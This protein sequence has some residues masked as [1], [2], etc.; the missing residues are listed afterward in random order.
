MFIALLA[1]ASLWLAAR[2]SLS[3]TQDQL[4]SVQGQISGVQSS[5]ASAT[6]KIA[7]D[8]SVAASRQAEHNAVPDSKAV[9]AKYFSSATGDAQSVELTISGLQVYTSI[10]Q[11]DANRAWIQFGSCGTDATRPRSGRDAD[12]RGQELQRELDLSP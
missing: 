6:A 5:L 12:G 3:R 11:E 10:A 9:A 1:T 7:S 8:Q 2:S 4:S